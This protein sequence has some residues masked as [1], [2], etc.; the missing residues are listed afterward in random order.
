MIISESGVLAHSSVLVFDARVVAFDKDPEPDEL[1]AA[2]AAEEEVPQPVIDLIQASQ[3]LSTRTSSA[4]TTTRCSDEAMSLFGLGYI[5][6]PM[7]D[8]RAAVLVG[9]AA[10]P[11]A[12]RRSRNSRTN[13]RTCPT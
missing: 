7:R 5:S 11:S 10:Y 9:G 13:S 8:R 2:M 6:P 4:P 12:S 3:D 1:D